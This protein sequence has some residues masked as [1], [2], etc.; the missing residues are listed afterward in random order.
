[1]SLKYYLKERTKSLNHSIAKWMFEVYNNLYYITRILSVC[2]SVCLTL[3][4]LGP[5]MGYRLETGVIRTSTTWT[6]D[7]VEKFSRKVTNGQITEEKLYA[8]N[9]FL[10]EKYR[11]F[12]FNVW[13]AIISFHFEQLRQLITRTYRVITRSCYEKF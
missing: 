9:A 11:A 8:T 13:K 5:W 6:R 4:R 1:M 3:Y 10:W 12:C 7:F 2:P